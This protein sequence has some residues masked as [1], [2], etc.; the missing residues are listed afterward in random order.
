MNFYCAMDAIKIIQKCEEKQIKIL[1]FDSFRISDNHIQPFME[2]SPNYSDLPQEMTWG[3]AIEDINSYS[4]LGF[5]F[6][7]VYE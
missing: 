7:I 4:D 2:Y 5:V 1:G 3:R 6:E